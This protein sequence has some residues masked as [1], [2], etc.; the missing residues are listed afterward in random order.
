[1]SYSQQN[2]DLWGQ[3]VGGKQSF[4]SPLNGKKKVYISTST[5]HVTV[6]KVMDVWISISRKY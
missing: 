1:M 5:Q 2:C 3:S 4:A 6:Y